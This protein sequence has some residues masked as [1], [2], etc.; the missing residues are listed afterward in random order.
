[1][2]TTLSTAVAAAA[3]A[4]ALGGCSNQDAGQPPIG[5]ISVKASPDDGLK[6]S[7]SAKARRPKKSRAPLAR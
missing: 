7:R 1:V 6:V 5:S 4:A 2:K 3:V